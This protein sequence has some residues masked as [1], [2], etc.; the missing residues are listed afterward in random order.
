MLLVFNRLDN[1]NIARV[2]SKGVVNLINGDP[3]AHVFA[4]LQNGW[5][6]LHHRL[7]YL[8]MRVMQ[9]ARELLNHPLLLQELLG[10][11]VQA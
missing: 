4:R 11:F 9:I 7:E 1:V 6:V 10:E 5:F 2:K 8:V 3:S